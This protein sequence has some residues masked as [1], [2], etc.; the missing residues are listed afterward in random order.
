MPRAP[1]L[2][3]ARRTAP[4][5]LSAGR[6]R[7]VFPVR[8]EP[9]PLSADLIQAQRDCFGAHTYRRIDQPREETFHFRWFDEGK[10]E[11]SRGPLAELHG[12]QV[13]DGAPEILSRKRGGLSMRSCNHA[14]SRSVSPAS[15]DARPTGSSAV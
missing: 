15:V 1:S 5:P 12:R 6:G 13:A 3:K 8:D 2:G 7:F 10:H 14:V 4:R 9:P 11:E